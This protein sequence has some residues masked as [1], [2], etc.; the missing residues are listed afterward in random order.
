MA[1]LVGHGP[2]LHPPRNDDHLPFSKVDR[3]IPE[4]HGEAAVQ[5]EEELILGVVM[6]PDELSLELHELYMLP[7][8]L[9]DD[10][11][12]PVRREAREALGELDIK[13][14]GTVSV[15]GLRLPRLIERK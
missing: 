9:G 1:L 3:S 5:H 14:K 8:E 7:V 15:F 12:V 10:L 11:R 6:V 4:L 2:V 13:G